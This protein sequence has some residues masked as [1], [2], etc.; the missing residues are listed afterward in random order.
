SGSCWPVEAF[1][2]IA[3][4]V[5]EGDARAIDERILLLLR[6]ADDPTRP[7]GPAWLADA[8]RDVTAL[9]GPA[10]LVLVVLAV[11][12]YLRIQRKPREMALVA[13]ASLGGPVLSTVLKESFARDRPTVV[14]P[15]APTFTASFPSGHAMLI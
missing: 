14:P 2:G 3:N 7:I 11:L 13:A 10:V 12:G 9:G 5:L 4:E 8:A 15:A 1:V 6:R